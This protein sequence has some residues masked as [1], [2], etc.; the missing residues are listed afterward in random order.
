MRHERWQQLSEDD[1]DAH[2]AQALVTAAY[3]A[4]HNAALKEAVNTLSMRLD[5]YERTIA[6]LKR[7]LV[8][9]DD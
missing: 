3:A 7:E 5:D 8:R 9:G 2:V 6:E 1:K 4:S